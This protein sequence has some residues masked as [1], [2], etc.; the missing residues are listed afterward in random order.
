M[1]S[2]ADLQRVRTWVREA[3]AVTV[4]AG[5]GISTDSGIP[6]F[7]GPQ[8]VWTRDPAAQ[9][10]FTLQNYLADPEV[11]RLAWRNRRSH[12][13]WTAA[14]N[15]GH[16]ALVELERSGRLRALL[17]Q[18]IDGLHQRA[19]SGPDRV[20][21]LHGT[22]WEVACLDCDARTAMREEL[23]RVDAGEPDPACRRCGGILKSATISFGQALVPEVLSRARAAAMDCELLLA[24]GSSLTVQ[25]A[26]GL[27]RIA[28][29]AGARLVVVNAEPTP[30]DELA[31]AVLR[32]PIGRVL[33][34]LVAGLDR[35]PARIR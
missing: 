16:R 19:G 27:C 24:V 13:A 35:S 9:Q 5:A 29:S 23:D 20:V 8:G 4:L 2:A 15:A 34:A 28:V 10:L 6:D 7:R 22:V 18:N 11:R 14:P 25:P 21:E 1:R 12:P 30:Y 3:A 17:T 32:E 31:A 26:A 33:P